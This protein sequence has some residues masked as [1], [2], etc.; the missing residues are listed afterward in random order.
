MAATDDR[1][2]AQRFTLPAA[3]LVWALVLLRVVHAFGPETEIND[4]PYSSDTAIPVL[5]ANDDRPFSPF[6]LYYYS[7][8]RF[9]AWAWALPALIHRH[10]GLWWTPHMLFVLQASWVF[11]GAIV[12]GALCPRDRYA[13]PLIYLFVLCLQRDGRFMLFEVGQVYAWIVT[14]LLVTW[15]CLR[16]LFRVEA[17]RARGRHEQ[18]MARSFLLAA[19]LLTLWSSATAA[20]YVTALLCLEA[21][22]AWL[23]KP[24]GG[25]RRWY[26]GAAWAV[27]LLATALLVDKVVRWLYLE[28]SLSEYQQDSHW[29]VSIDSGFLGENLRRH[30][31]T[32]AAMSWF[33]L[34]VAGGLALLG[35]VVWCLMRF[36][37]SGRAELE[38]RVKPVVGDDG[39][40]FALGALA[41]A[42][43]S[44]VLVVVVDQVRHSSYDTRYLTVTFQFAPVAGLTAFYL[45]VERGARGWWR[46][47]GLVFVGVAV[48]VLLLALPG[49][50]PSPG[51]EI[52]KRIAE[53]LARKAPGGVLVGGYWETYVFTS[54]QARHTM[55]AV[56]LQ[57]SR[58]PWTIDALRSA[59]E[60]VV[61]YLASR[62]G[63]ADRPPRHIAPHGYRLRLKDA[64]FHSD[65]G[66]AFALYVKPEADAPF[67]ES[68][69]GGDT[70]GWSRSSGA[71][72]P[73]SPE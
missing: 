59:D 66:Y 57:S 17:L 44:F 68:F 29:H 1:A 63:V 65:A 38:T 25:G 37:R 16:R 2:R 54:L 18:W 22:R 31:A 70:G 23:A 4:F 48:A 21:F 56:P 5:M 58:T 13:V 11:L 24:A 55:T 47:S 36:A 35:L 33:P 46:R 41:I 51:Y 73:R 42:T 30:L 50:Q 34:Y 62:L 19:L 12:I 69:E 32:V 40:L 27:G 7:A 3:L 26:A 53:E 52:A 39:V 20:P 6:S 61:E 45:A 60:V 14:S 28:H 9:G 43:L 71:T 15:L 67:R 10:T 64:G 8:D 49:R 72:R